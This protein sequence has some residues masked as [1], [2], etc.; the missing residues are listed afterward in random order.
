MDEIRV[1]FNDL[2]PKKQ[3]EVLEAYGIMKPEEMNW[4]VFPLTVIV[5]END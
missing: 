5:F 4:D 1:M 2:I 3:Q